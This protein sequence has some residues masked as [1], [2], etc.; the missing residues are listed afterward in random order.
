[1]RRYVF[2]IRVDAHL[3]PLPGGSAWAA[4]TDSEGDELAAQ[5]IIP[6]PGATVDQ[7]LDAAIHTARRLDRQT[8]EQLQLSPTLPRKRPLGR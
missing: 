7:V 3:T 2:C 1:V 8:P 4:V 6:V 5:T